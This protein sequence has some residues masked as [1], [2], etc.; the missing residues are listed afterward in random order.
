MQHRMELFA[1]VG[2]RHENQ[3]NYSVARFSSS[4]FKSCGLKFL[5]K[6]V[7][8]AICVNARS[9]FLRASRVLFVL[10]FLD[11]T[12]LVPEIEVMDM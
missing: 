4:R 7:F 1:C 12:T 10:S 9:S 6:L 5:R 11:G 8:G 2:A 3:A